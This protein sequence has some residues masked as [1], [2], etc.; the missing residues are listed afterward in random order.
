MHRLLLLSLLSLGLTG[1]AFAD[2]Y[3]DEALARVNQLEQKFIGLAKAMPQDTMTWRPMEGVRSVSELYLHIAGADL[4]LTAAIGT[5]PPAGFDRKGYEQ[6]TTDK[7]KIVAELEK[8]FAH[9]K[10]A[11]NALP[12][13]GQENATKIFGRDTTLRGATWTLLEHASEHLGQA[14]AYARSNKVVP[15]WT[16]ARQ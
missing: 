7:A 12:D 15:P 6:S 14:I 16:A 11:I 1:S 5:P 2:A 4:G 8:G 13:G 10:K 3:K 9:M